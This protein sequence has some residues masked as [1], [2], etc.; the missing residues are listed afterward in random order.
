MAVRFIL[1]PPEKRGEWMEKEAE[2]AK[3]VKKKAT[4]NIWLVTGVAL[5][6]FR[7]VEGKEFG[8]LRWYTP[9]Q[10]CK[11][12]KTEGLRKEQDLLIACV[13]ITSYNQH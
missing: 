9:G 5:S 12:L 13:K 10:Q 3:E 2:E 8:I 7:A 6:V 4:G 1:A 11:S